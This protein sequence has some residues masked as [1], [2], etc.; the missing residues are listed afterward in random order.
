[1]AKLRL[2][3]PGPF[4]RS[5]VSAEVLSMGSRRTLDRP[6]SPGT[7]LKPATTASVTFIVPVGGVLELVATAANLFN[8]SY[9]DPASDAHLQDTILQNGRTFRVGA[10]WKL[11]TK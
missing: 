3:V 8:L 10:T 2:S 5:F 11:W 9:A 4:A 7:T 1:M 6:T